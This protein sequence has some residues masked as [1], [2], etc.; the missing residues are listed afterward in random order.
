MLK[1]LSTER[2]LKFILYGLQYS[3]GKGELV[4][5]KEKGEGMKG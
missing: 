3:M 4:P 1:R 5:P 2:V